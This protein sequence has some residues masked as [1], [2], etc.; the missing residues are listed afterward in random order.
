[1]GV[2]RLAQRIGD[3]TVLQKILLDMPGGKEFCTRN[4]YLEGAEVF[5]SQKRRPNTPIGDDGD[6]HRPDTMNFS[7]LR[8]DKRVTRS[9]PET[10]PT[11]IEESSPSVQDV[12]VPSPGG[13]GFHRVNVVQKTKVDVSHWH[14]IRIPHTSGKSCWANHAGTKKKKRTVKIATNNKSVPASTYTGM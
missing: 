6:T 9:Q 5:G 11:L 10:L 2:Q 4:P 14:I 1:M 7:R 8:P 12:Q 13:I 3:P